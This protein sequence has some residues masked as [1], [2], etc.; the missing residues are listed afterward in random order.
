MTAGPLIAAAGLALMARISPGSG[1]IPV[2]LPAVAVFG[3]G[4]SV[5]VAPLTSAVLASAAASRAGLVSGINNAIARIAGLFAIAALPLLARVS[6]TKG[7]LGP[8][9][10]RAML[11]AAAVCAAGGLIAWATIPPQRPG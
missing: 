8:G 2:V 6:V 3:R 4:L 10:G 5:T 9:F 7:Q 11:I 1:F